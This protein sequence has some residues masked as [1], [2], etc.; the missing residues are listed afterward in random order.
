MYGAGIKFSSLGA[1]VEFASSVTQSINVR[2]GGNFFNYPID[3]TRDDVT[4]KGNVRLHSV[5]AHIDWFPT[6]G[7]F[8]VGPGVLYY[9]SSPFN[10]NLSIPGGT[11]FS[12]N[13]TDFVSSPNNP[14]T[15]AASMHVHRIAPEIT[16]GWGNL[17][18]RGEGKHWSIPFEIG[19]AYQGDPRIQI[20]LQGTACAPKGGACYDAATDPAVLTPLA[21]EVK[22]R[23]N[24]VSWFRFYPIISIGV[25]YRF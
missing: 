22:H 9:L 21:Q 16:V 10:A 15:G 1:G 20:G 12:L 19:A 25:G 5:E 2:M 7:N 18:P 3:N 8:H 24:D 13:T 23:E 14:I 6:H 11:E 17:L 4:Y